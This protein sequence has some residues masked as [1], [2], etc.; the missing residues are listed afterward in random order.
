MNS[1][2]TKFLKDEKINK[3]HGYTKIELACMLEITQFRIE[4]KGFTKNGY[5]NFCIFTTVMH[6]RGSLQRDKCQRK[7]IKIQ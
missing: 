7:S 6:P 4:Y 1:K 5:K 2:N 3:H